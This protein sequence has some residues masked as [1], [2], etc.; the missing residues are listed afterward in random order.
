MNDKWTKK[1]TPIGKIVA[2][3]GG[4]GI[5][6]WI[7]LLKTCMQNPEQEQVPIVV[8]DTIIVRVVGTD[9]IKDPKN[10][11][12]NSLKSTDS[13][14]PQ[15][16]PDAPTKQ[17]ITDTRFENVGETPVKKRFEATGERSG[18]YK[19]EKLALDAAKE[20]AEKELSR[21]LQKSDISYEIDNEKST[22]Y[23]V[24]DYGYKAKIVIFTYK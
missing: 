23:F 16:T 9:E 14:I 17:K 1:I 24:K 7:L 10:Q 6:G 20:E 5:V 21:I 4:G 22:V 3:I 12:I 13:N 15:T 8:K 11:E 2:I 19:S 18:Y